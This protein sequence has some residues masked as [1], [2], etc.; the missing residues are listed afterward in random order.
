MLSD[1]LSRNILILLVA[2][3]AS[4]TGT[5]A[6][7][8]VGGILGR[9]LAG[10]PALA[11]L[12]LSMLIVATALSTIVAASIMSRIGRPRGFALGAALG[13]AG[14]GCAW[15]ATAVGS[16]ALFCL[17]SI[18]IGCA[19]AFSQQYRFA[20]TE[21]VRAAA[22]PTAVAVVLTGSMVGALLGPG[23]V[24]RGESWIAGAQFGGSFAA[25]A[26][27]YLLA[28]AVLLALRPA[29]TE[30][31][32]ESGGDIRPLRTIARSRLFV[33]A[34]VGAAMGQG[35]MA[36]MMT[37]APLA[38]HVVDG[39]SLAATAAVIQAH[40]LAMYAPSLVAGGLITRFGA[41]RI[42]MTGA[43]LLGATLAA[44]LA[45][46]E[47]MHYGMAMVALGFGWN[48]LYVGGTTLLARSY[49]PAERFRVQGFND[50]IVLGCAALGSLSA[51]AV[52]QLLGW[53]AVL[54][55][56]MPAIMLAMAAIIWGRPDR[57][58]VVAG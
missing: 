33:V 28:G 16:F 50:F 2:Q 8:T 31:P 49:R 34:V 48:F 20:A 7:V 58:G 39:H 27:C 12:P 42:M 5:V 1:L 25:M 54:Y 51:G 22:A 6:I 38:M 24:A 30:A 9:A 26:A 52:M 32:E 43:I 47:I 40:V 10:N 57:Q 11:T 17:G 37:A 18:L 13:A 3:A 29:S 55:A 19:T 23:L 15:A 4:V 21:S 53:D 41:G 45:G 56:S 44:G 46:R 35:V 36:F 14:A